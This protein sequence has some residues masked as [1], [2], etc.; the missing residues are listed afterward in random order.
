MDKTEDGARW[1]SGIRDRLDGHDGRMLDVDDDVALTRIGVV[2][3][4][5]LYQ[6]PPIYSFS[7][8]PDILCAEWQ[9]ML[10]D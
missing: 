6:R 8:R 9:I 2:M 4:H 1:L 5:P 10:W 3:T 7:G